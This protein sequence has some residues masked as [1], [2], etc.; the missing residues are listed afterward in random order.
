MAATIIKTANL[1]ARVADKYKIKLHFT[2]IE[3]F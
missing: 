3:L 2:Q 1:T